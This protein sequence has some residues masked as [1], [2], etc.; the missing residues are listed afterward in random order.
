MA[1]LVTIIATAS[2]IGIIDAIMVWALMKISAKEN[3]YYDNLSKK[4]FDSKH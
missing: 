1:N 3:E 2:A 4:E